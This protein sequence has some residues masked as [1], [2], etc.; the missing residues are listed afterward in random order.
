MPKL[1]TPS[2]KSGFFAPSFGHECT[3]IL[4]PDESFPTLSVFPLGLTTSRRFLGEAR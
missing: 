2:L 3:L 1:P 4:P